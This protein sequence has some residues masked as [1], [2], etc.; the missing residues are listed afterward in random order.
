M[1]TDSGLVQKLMENGHKAM[2]RTGWAEAKEC[3]KAALEI[4]ETPDVLESL[5]LA[6]W[7]LDDADTTFKA[8]EKAFQ[9][10]RGQGNA[11]AAARVAISIAYDYFSFRGEYALSN[12]WSR[13]AHRLLKKL[14]TVPEH[15][16]LK[17]WDGN[18]AIEAEHDPVKALQ[19]GKEAAKIA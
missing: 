6:A 2:E 19:L 10:Y 9:L 18:V 12:G 4:K 16:W 11:R 17:A 15:G 3:Y 1:P 8:R 13:R 7:W 14:D 5:G